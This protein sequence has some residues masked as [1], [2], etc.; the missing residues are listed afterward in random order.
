MKNSNKKKF[1]WILLSKAVKY[2]K[3]K[4]GEKG[5]ENLDFVIFGVD[6][7]PRKVSTVYRKRF[8]I[9]ASYR[10]RNLV[11]PRTESKDAT[12]SY[13]YALIS[14]LL[15]NVWLCLQRMHFSIAKTG[16]MTINDDLIRFDLFI[17]LIEEWVKHKLKVKSSVGC[18]R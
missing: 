12:V 7:S 4:G 15:K 13:F 2:L 8:A 9:E 1:C 10:M 5:R 3:G 14:F 18:I 11:G 6:W 16:P 17:L